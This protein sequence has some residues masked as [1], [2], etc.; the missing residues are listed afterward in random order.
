MDKHHQLSI[1]GDVNSDG[2]VNIQD[3][4]RIQKHILGSINLGGSE[5]YASDVNADGTVNIQDLLRVQKYL[6][7]SLSL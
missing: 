5:Y 3:L 6:L 4:L 7:G 2:T 1:H